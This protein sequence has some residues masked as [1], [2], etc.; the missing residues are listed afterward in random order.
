MG[1]QVTRGEVNTSANVANFLPVVLALIFLITYT[2]GMLYIDYLA[3][4]DSVSL[5]FCTSP[6]TSTPLGDLLTLTTGVGGLVSALVVAVLGATRPNTSP[7]DIFQSQSIQSENQRRWYSFSISAYM[8]VWLLVGLVTLIISVLFADG[9]S[10]ANLI[11]H[12]VGFAWSG[13]A[14]AAVYAYF[15]IAPNKPNDSPNQP[16]QTLS[17]PKEK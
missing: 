6:S 12:D 5:P 3:F 14:L 16:P 1:Q 10:P 2:L 17:Q 8:I 7:T 11:A 13:M 9:V 4:C 15:G